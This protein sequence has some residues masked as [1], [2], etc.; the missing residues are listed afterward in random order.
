MRR[1]FKTSQPIWSHPREF[2]FFFFFSTK[3]PHVRLRSWQVERRDIRNYRSA[4]CLLLPRRP[5][6][7]C[8]PK[9]L[10][11]FFSLRRGGTASEKEGGSCRKPPSRTRL[12]FHRVKRPSKKIR[13][14]ETREVETGVRG[15]WSMAK[16]KWPRERE[17]RETPRGRRYFENH[18]EPSS[19]CSLFLRPVSLA[20]EMDEERERRRRENSR[21]SQSGDTWRPKVHKMRERKREEE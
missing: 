18:S 21:E 19:R 17:K 7:H 6:R 5:R 4:S 8:E 2:L 1:M 10:L 11:A 16:I 13:A 12:E 14:R 9:F 20:R 3:I 15:A